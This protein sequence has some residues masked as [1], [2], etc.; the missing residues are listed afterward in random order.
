MGDFLQKKT[1]KPQKN[2][3]V[4][5]KRAKKNGNRLTREIEEFPLW[6]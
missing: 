4:L 2:P 3:T 5:P 1:K 6:F